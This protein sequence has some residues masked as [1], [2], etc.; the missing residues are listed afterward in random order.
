[1]HI[2]KAEPTDVGIILHFIKA[3]AAYE[4]LSHEVET[5]EE[6]LNQTLFCENPYAEVLLC[7]E[8]EIPVGFALYFYNYSTFRAKPGIYLE[9]LFV[10]PQHRAKGYGKA[11]FQELITLANHN[12]LGRVE[13]SVLDW[14]TPAIDFY[15]AMGAKAMDEW[16]VYR[17]T[18]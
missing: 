7:F 6:K 2:R 10:E 8:N 11:L 18:I 4:K 12:Q 5:T 13:W 17:I 3:I 16:T 1:M 15:K 14:N 9:D